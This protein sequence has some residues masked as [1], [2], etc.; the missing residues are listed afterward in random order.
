MFAAIVEFL[1]GCGLKHIS[2]STLIAVVVASG[3]VVFAGDNRY[4]LKD[5]G[6]QIQLIQQY[7]LE[8]KLLM[9]KLREQNMTQDQIDAIFK[10]RWQ[11]RLEL[12]QKKNKE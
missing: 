3:I 6:Q 11:G 1:K 9:M 8:D 2:V 4:L 7:E 5:E 10:E 12:M